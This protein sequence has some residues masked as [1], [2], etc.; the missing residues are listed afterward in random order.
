MKY[1]S[2]SIFTT[3]L[4]ALILSGCSSS[5]SDS[6]PGLD[7]DLT[8]EVQ[9]PAESAFF[10]TYYTWDGNTG[11]FNSE[12]ITIPQSGLFEYNVEGSDFVGF[13]IILGPIGDVEAVNLALLSDGEIIAE[14]DQPVAD[15][16]YEL[17]FGTIPDELPSSIE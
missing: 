15:G 11:D 1:L 5:G 4:L 12:T 7:G 13:G 16:A 3:L 8:I 17:E 2:I 10:L 6:E 9:A 14:T